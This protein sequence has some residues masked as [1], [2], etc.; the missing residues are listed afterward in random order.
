MI[1]KLSDT[2][3]DPSTILVNLGDPAVLERLSTENNL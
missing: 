3:S 2:I 1:E